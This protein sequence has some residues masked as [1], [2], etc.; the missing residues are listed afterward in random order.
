MEV[1]LFVIFLMFVF[2]FLVFSTMTELQDLSPSPV[3][4][5]TQ[6]PYSY[7]PQIRAIIPD[8]PIVITPSNIRMVSSDARIV[9]SPE[10]SYQQSIPDSS[11]FPHLPSVSDEIPEE[12]HV[13]K[14]KR[15]DFR[16]ESEMVCCEVLEELLN[17]EVQINIRPD[18]L[19]NPKTKRNLE[20]DCYYEKKIGDRTIKLAVEYQGIQ[21]YS[22]V[23]RFHKKGIEDLEYTKW[24][25]EYKKKICREK[26]I[27]LI[28]VP[29]I[30]DCGEMD[31]EG[32][33]KYIPRPLSVRR[34]KIFEFLQPWI[35]DIFCF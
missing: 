28:C 2:T 30:V 12:K 29:Y 27:C 35:Y 13:F 21:H 5:R 20:L 25:D 11:F 10:T 31:H 8:Q 26:G 14:K 1:L 6:Y 19:K 7:Y 16:S 17:D 18:F 4:N 24:K 23:S 3:N 15:S 33:W 32:N 34:K 9:Y 22:Y